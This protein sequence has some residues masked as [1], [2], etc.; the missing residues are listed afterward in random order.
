ME[1]VFACG[2][3]ECEQLGIPDL[4]QAKLPRAL[5]LPEEICM[6]ACGSMHTLALSNEGKVYSWG[7][8]DDGALGRS[9]EENRP[10]IVTG[11]HSVNKLAAGDSHSVAISEKLKLV[12]SWGTYRN[13]EGKMAIGNKFPVEIKQFLKSK[14]IMDVASGGN[15]SLVLV[16]NKIYAW[17]DSEFGQ[18]GRMPRSRKSVAASLTVE[19]M[20]AKSVTN[21]YTGRNHSFYKA[22]GKIY[23][24]GLNNYG[25]LGDGSTKSTFSPHEIETLSEYEII[26]IQ[27]GENHSIALTDSGLLLAWGRNDDFQLGLN[28]SQDYLVPQIVQFNGKIQEISVGSHFNFLVTET[29]RVFSW[30]YGDCFVL[31]NGK[32]KNLSM[33]TLVAWSVIKPVDFIRAGSQHVVFLRNPGKL[34]IPNPNITQLKTRQKAL[35]SP[36]KKRNN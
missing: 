5:E 22:Y 1:Q 15:H 12:Y 25:Q 28:C 14:R 30:G 32:E 8:N 17:G 20:A 3:G 18:I 19:S 34:D 2:S 4:F 23:G 27:G 16:D 29:K 9:G 6:I 13:S 7:C 33:P 36:K 11:V 35:T 21:I 24:W 31:M 26:D 10:C